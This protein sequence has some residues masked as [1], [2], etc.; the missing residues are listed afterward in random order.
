MFWSSEFELLRFVQDQLR[1][2]SASQH[3]ASLF[4][5]R[6]RP[7][8]HNDL[9]GAH[10]RILGQIRLQCSNV[11]R[12]SENIWEICCLKLLEAGGI[13]RSGTGGSDC[14]LPYVSILFSIFLCLEM[15]WIRGFRRY[16]VVSPGDFS[17]SQD[18]SMVESSADPRCRVA[19]LLSDQPCSCRWGHGALW[20]NPSGCWD[21]ASSG[22]LDP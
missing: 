18:I 10:I 5:S 16:L 12:E 7:G 13:A 15:C 11:L 8:A 4:P 6:S 20:G 19:A 14:C 3:I 2:I 22:D 17:M 21:L 9:V 1:N